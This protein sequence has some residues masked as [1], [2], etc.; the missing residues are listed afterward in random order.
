MSIHNW[1]LEPVSYGAKLRKKRFNLKEGE[2]TI[3]KTK[4]NSICVPSVLCSRAHC[5]IL[6]RQDQVFLMDTVSMLLGT[7]DI[8]D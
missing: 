1:L 8:F 4:S 6:L 2:N 5:K 3:G 7:S